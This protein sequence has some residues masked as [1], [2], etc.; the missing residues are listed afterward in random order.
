M[1]TKQKDVQQ[2]VKKTAVDQEKSTAQTQDSEDY[3]I[4]IAEAAY[5]IAEKRRF[6]PS[7]EMDDWFEA[8]QQ[9]TGKTEKA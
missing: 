6:A 1:A 3:Q 8:E 2:K 9:I 5:Y 7:H 4:M